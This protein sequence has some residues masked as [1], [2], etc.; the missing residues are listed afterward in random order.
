[1]NWKDWEAVREVTEAMKAVQAEALALSGAFR[2][3]RLGDE[4]KGAVWSD[5]MGRIDSVLENER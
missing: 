3:L 2:G 1:M 5:V 4:A